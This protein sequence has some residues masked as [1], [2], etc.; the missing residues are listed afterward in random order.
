MANVKIKNLTKRYEKTAAINDINLEIKDGELFILL[1]PSGC[2]KT[3]TLLCIAGLIKPDE[4]EIW[5][6]EEMVT[7]IENHI[8]ERPQDRNVAM[9]FQDYAIYP[10]MTVFKNIAFP[11]AI[12]KIHKDEIEKK[13][14][15]VAERLEISQL[16]DRKPK[17]LSGGQRQRVALARAIVREPNAF[18]MDEPL[19]NL[20]AKLRVFARAEL[21]RLHKRLG[22]TIVYVT[23]D[24]LEAMSI[25]DRIAILNNGSLEQLDTPDKIYNFPKN[26]FVAGFIGSPPMNMLDGTL[27]EKNGKKYIDLGFKTY[28]LPNRFNNLKIPK[29]SDVVL[30]VRPEHISISRE[31]VANSIK[32][33]VDIVEDMG[34][35]FNI[36]LRANQKPIIVIEKSAEDLKIGDE[37]NLV[38]DDKKIHMFDKHTEENL[39]KKPY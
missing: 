5:L 17:Q 33:K 38:F 36:H 16:L 35:E 2:G 19:S 25:G 27:L 37:L 7:G 23:H 18:L 24:Q 15:E 32:A 28:E 11:L 12:R 22:I 8:Y 20:D 9:V 13:V 31:D 10:H 4:G 6:G 30:G 3:T 21:K 34:R 1:G 39:L 14:K 29:T 26:I